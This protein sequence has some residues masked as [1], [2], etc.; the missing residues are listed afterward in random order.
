MQCSLT[1][2]FYFYDDDLTFSDIK[3]SMMARTKRERNKKL[4]ERTE[5]L[6]SSIAKSKYYCY[7]NKNMS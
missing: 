1:R 7:K 5:E 4:N 6:R 2:S 3:D